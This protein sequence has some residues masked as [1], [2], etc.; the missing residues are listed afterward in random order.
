[1][2]FRNFSFALIVLACGF[3]LWNKISMPF[4]LSRSEVLEKS[5]PPHSTSAKLRLPSSTSPTS[6]SSNLPN[7]EVWQTRY[8]AK[9]PAALRDRADILLTPS[10]SEIWELELKIDGI[11]VEGTD[12][13]LFL[14]GSEWTLSG[15]TWPAVA[16][17]PAEFPTET[18]N[19][20][21][22]LRNLLP[23]ANSTTLSD[24]PQKSW[25][26]SDGTLVPCLRYDVSYW[27]ESARTQKKETWAVNAE[28]RKIISKN[29]RVRN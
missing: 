14:M 19:V 2:S 18:E 21:E 9:L 24:P 23:S 8:R 15:G 7:L 11:R 20:G 16:M 27:D 26:P 4:F 29:P 12:G 25:I 28:T 13:R 5:P 3:Y 22:L 10:N 1:M 17:V 6:S